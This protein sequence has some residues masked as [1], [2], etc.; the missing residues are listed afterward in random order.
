MSFLLNQT[1]HGAKIRSKSE[2]EADSLVGDGK[3][4]TS[5]ARL[6]LAGGG[7]LN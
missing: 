4:R 6:E 1:E 2:V 3:D 7:N 5:K